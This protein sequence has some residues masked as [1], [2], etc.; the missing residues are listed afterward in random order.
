MQTLPTAY[1]AVISYCTA[2]FFN[3]SPCT[4]LHCSSMHRSAPHCTEGGNKRLFWVDLVAISGHT[5]EA[6][7]TSCGKF[8]HYTLLKYG[9]LNMSKNPCHRI[10]YH[11]HLID[12]YHY[13]HINY[14]IK[15]V[16]IKIVITSSSPSSS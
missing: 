15:I 1:L 8:Q 12:H 4:I 10:L 9:A 16:I 6:Y 14:H 3:S 5:A 13:N 11:H 7:Q 2:L